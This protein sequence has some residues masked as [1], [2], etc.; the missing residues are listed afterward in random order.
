MA[1]R[2]DI[3]LANLA[4]NQEPLNAMVDQLNYSS[5]NAPIQHNWPEQFAA[6]DIASAAPRL[7]VLVVNPEP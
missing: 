1:Q 4:E 5:A 7:E 3:D 6:F 2:K